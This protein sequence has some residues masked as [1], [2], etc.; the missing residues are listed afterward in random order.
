MV[1]NRTEFIFMN[2][3]HAY[4]HMFLL[5][6][7]TVVLTLGDTFPNKAYGDLLFPATFGFIAFGL[8]SLPAGWLGDF[9]SRQGMMVVFFIGI[10]CAS[11]LT[12]LADNLFQISIGLA[13]IGLFAAIY[14]P[15]GISMVSQNANEVGKAMGINGVVGNL[16]LAAA[17]LI[18][19]TLIHYYDWRTAF[20]VPGIVS[21]I[22]GICYWVS[23]RLGEVKL[24]RVKQN[25]IL[26][27][28]RR[29][30]IIMVWVIA[31]AAAC[32]GIIF[33][34]TTVSLPKVFDE[35]LLE[36]ESS[37][38]GVAWIVAAILTL[39]SITQVIIGYLL[40]KYSLRIIFVGV[41]SIQVPALA[42][43]ATANNWGMVG[44][45]I[46]MMVGVFGQIPITDFIIAKYTASTW[47]AR[48]YALKY[49]LSFFVSIAAVPLVGGLRDYSG[50]F[51]LLFYV[52]AGLAVLVLVAAVVIPV[53][54]DV[55]QPAK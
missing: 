42:L 15:V 22:T 1:K 24:G 17:P 45:T 30:Q 41:V 8:C 51:D 28:S 16:G 54:R 2:I 37:M 11:I 14:H 5:F 7:A 21:I 27:L 12:G 55:K 46:I 53:D 4:D 18:A 47:R 13:A 50:S 10:G 9:W 39:A 48:M 23:C 33:N 36:V 20:I 26:T 40:D 49:S 29:N 6:Y 34:S 3:A 38:L 35:R 32:G 43:A 52:L 44:I 19:G 25:T 31:V